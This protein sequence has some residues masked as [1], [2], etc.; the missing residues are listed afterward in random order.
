MKKQVKDFT[1]I[2]FGSLNGPLPS[3]T[4]CLTE[5]SSFEDPSFQQGEE[6]SSDPDLEANMASATQTMHNQ[7]TRSI[8]QQANQQLLDAVSHTCAADM[9]MELD[10]AG[11]KLI[12]KKEK[13]RCPWAWMKGT[14]V[15][16]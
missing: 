10:P 15:R 1:N 4:P 16:Y 3:E 8:E 9:S 6:A 11:E 5:P 12:G 14:I 2:Y 7:I 13:I